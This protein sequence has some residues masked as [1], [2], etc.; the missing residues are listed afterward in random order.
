MDKGR[1]RED[2]QRRANAWASGPDLTNSPPPSRDDS[3]GAVIARTSSASGMERQGG[4]EGPL[5]AEVRALI[6]GSCSGEAAEQAEVYARRLLST[7]RRVRVYRE[8]LSAAVEEVD[9]IKSVAKK[10]TLVCDA[11][12]QEIS[13]IDAKIQM[14]L[15]ERQM[16]QVQLE[17]EAR[18][19]ARNEG[20]LNEGDRRVEVLRNTIDNITR[21]TQR[22][23]MLL[24]QLVPN[25]QIE[26]Y[27]T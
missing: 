18:N 4:M 27:C 16:C 21:E 25:L 26:N 11:L 5:P 7:H 20:K 13:S 19:L 2:M 10:N 15:N 14:L 6:H 3:Q 17:S 24:R 8:E 9:D 1:I 12:K 22:G 23:H